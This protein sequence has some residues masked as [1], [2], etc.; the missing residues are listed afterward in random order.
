MVSVFRIQGSEY[1][2]L[3]GILFTK[4]VV[5]EENIAVTHQPSGIKRAVLGHVDQMLG[6]TPFKC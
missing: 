5:S 6:G 4:C 2:P 1:E 3:V